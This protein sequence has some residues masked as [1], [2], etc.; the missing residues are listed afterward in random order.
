VTDSTSG[1]FGILEIWKVKIDCICGAVER[2]KK[3]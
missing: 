2:K 1:M 3:A